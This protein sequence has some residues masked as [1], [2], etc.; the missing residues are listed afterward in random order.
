VVKKMR[1]ESTRAGKLGE[2][3]VN[4][5]LTSTLAYHEIVWTRTRGPTNQ[6]F[7]FEIYLCGRCVCL[8]EVKAFAPG[9]KWNWT[10]FKRPAIRRKV[11]RAE[12]L[13]CQRV[14]TVVVKL[15]TGEM[16]YAEGFPSQ[17]FDSFQ[18]IEGLIN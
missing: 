17:P 18:P 6:A 2:K 8:L 16:R 10:Q 5:M 13:H 14:C 4:D 15:D 12:T 1:A 3:L 11:K 9:R 7:D